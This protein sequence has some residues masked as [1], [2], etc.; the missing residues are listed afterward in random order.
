MKPLLSALLLFSVT[1]MTMAQEMWDLPPILYS[2][3]QATDPIAQM[4][5]K[6]TSLPQ[7]NEQETLLFLLG[8]LDIS[9]ASQILVFSKTSAQNYFISPRTPRALYFNENAYVGHVLG[10]GF[11]III[12]DDRLGA[13]FYFIE[14]ERDGRRLEIERNTT[15]CLNCH[16]TRRTELVPG[17]TVRSVPTDADGN[18]LLSLGSTRTDHR[19]PLP[20]RWAGYYVTGGSTLPHLGNRTFSLEAGLLPDRPQE[21]LRTVAGKVDTSRYL[22]DTSDIVALMVLEHQCLMHNLLI[23]ASMEYRR[24]EWLNKAKDLDQITRLAAEKAV[25]IVDV[26]LFKDEAPVGDGGVDGS[27]TFQN[28]FTARFPKTDDGDSL[29]DFHLGNRLFKNRCSYMI[30]SK[31]FASLPTPLRK[32]VLHELKQRITSGNRCGWI[33]EGERLRI[34]QILRE[35]VPGFSEVP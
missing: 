9:E 5:E 18:L 22:T 34:L 28:A 1:C 26:M 13:V 24:A 33:P 19:T 15:A 11:E 3:T 8:L 20:K 17:L 7:G 32:A 14:P 31:A 35:T 12:H 21:I 6:G 30:H 27:P 4:L 23:N 25:G 2:K 16:A 10:G 29:A